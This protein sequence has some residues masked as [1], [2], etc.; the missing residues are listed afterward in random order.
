MLSYP[1]QDDRGFY[2]GKSWGLNYNN[3]FD[4]NALHP[5]VWSAMRNS[6]SVIGGAINFSTNYKDSSAGGIVWSTYLIFVGFGKIGRSRSKVLRGSLTGCRMLRGRVGFLA[7]SDQQSTTSRWN[8]GPHV[9][10]HLLEAG[11]QRSE[12]AFVS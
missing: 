11:V 5:G 12:A 3:Q 4:I 1:P 9:G 6:G 8:K 7:L 10:E 2:L